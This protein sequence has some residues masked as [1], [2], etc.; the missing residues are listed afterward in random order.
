MDVNFAFGKSGIW[1]ALPEGRNYSVVE[2]RSAAPIADVQRALAAAL[3][4]PID[5]APLVELAHGK[6]TAAIAVCDITR[7]APNRITLPPL[8]ER[9]HAAGIDREHVTIL[10][11]TG[12]HR[13]ATKAE[14]ETIVGP[15]VASRYRVENH[16]AK[17]LAAHSS[18]GATQRGTPVYIDT[19]FA[20]ADLRITLGFIEQHIMAGFSGGRKLVAPGLAAQETIKVL[21]SPKF[22]REPMAT[23]GSV[24]GNPLHEELLEIARLA[25]HD[26]MLDV[27]LTKERKISGVFSGNPVVAHAA[28]VK[29]M[30]ESSM[31]PLPEMVDAVITSSA[32]YPLDL[33]FYQTAKGIT[34]AQH[35]VKRGGRILLLGECTEGIGSPEFAEKLRSFSSEREYLESIAN[36]PVVPDQWQLE[37]VALVGMDRQLFFYTPGV[38]ADEIGAYG[39]RYF[40]SPEDAVAAVLD[41]LPP[42]ARVAVI[43]EGPYAYARV[44]EG[45]G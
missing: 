36:Q 14:V 18:L 2:S 40:L 35:I 29:F 45:N 8:L 11:A 24:E 3:D 21:H 15:E 23:E 28:G 19:R 5:C 26:F 16:D 42:D 9:L 25:K 30:R 32:G 4:R 6:Q 31:F 12:L 38:T 17:D 41:G 22:M 43:P 27:T 20:E 1:V 39:E 37:K 13:G 7:P 34:A 44:S 33:T 10:I